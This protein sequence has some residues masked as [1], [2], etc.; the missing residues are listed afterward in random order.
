[1]PGR[2]SSVVVSGVRIVS[3]LIGRQEAL[4]VGVVVHRG[5]RLKN[6]RIIIT[7]KLQ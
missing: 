3:H 4:K 5:G 1:M 2:E 6:D 7:N